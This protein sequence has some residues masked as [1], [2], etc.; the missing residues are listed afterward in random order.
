[1][2]KAKFDIKTE[3][4]RPIYAGVG[5]TDLAVGFVREYVADVQ[6]RFAGVQKDVQA[7]VT[8]LD[9]EPKALRD[10]A[11]TVVSARVDALSKDAKARRTAIEARVAELQSALNENVASVGDTYADL[12]KRGEILVGR[13]RNQESTKATVKSARTTTAKAKTTKTQ[14]SKA[15]STTAKKT[16]KKASTTAK[17]SSTAPKSSAKAT[18]TAAKKT[19]SNAASA[20]T[21]AASKVGN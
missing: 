14:A 13:I 16:A 1:M 5:V 9:L 11:A 12:A 21:D 18:A 3:A 4:T 15:T 8:G 20:T 10:Q 6:K 7:R 19:A 2:A 17:K